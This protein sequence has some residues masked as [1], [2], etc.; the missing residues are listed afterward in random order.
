MLPLNDIRWASYQGGYRLI[1]DASK[2]L[3]RLI[4]GEATDTLWQELWEDLYHQGDVGEA[5]YAAVPWLLEITRRSPQPDWNPL[6][7]ICTIEL[8]RPSPKNPEV[9]QELRE[10]YFNAIQGIP[11]ALAEKPCLAWDD[12]FTQAAVAALALSRGHRAF[13]E[14]YLEFGFQEAEKWLSEYLEIEVDE[15]GLQKL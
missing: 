4:Q 7:L 1:Y 12:L 6:V 14:I 9:P 5:S 11:L 2:I 8:A 3:S 15:L 13:A 10:G